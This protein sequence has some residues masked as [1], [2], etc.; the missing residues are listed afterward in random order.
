MVILNRNRTLSQ[1][2]NGLVVSCQPRLNSPLDRAAFV[3]AMAA[4]AE[5]Q[6]AAAVRIRGARDIRAVCRTVRIPVI[7]IEKMKGPESEVY[8][9]PT[10]ESVRHVYRAGARII[11]MDATERPRPY[12]QSLAGIVAATRD[13]CDVLLM[14]DVATLRQGVEAARLGFDL[15]GTTL[16]GYTKETRHCKGP[17]FDLA[18][19]LVRE[20]DIPVILEGRVHKPDDVRRAF[21]LGTHAVVVGTAITDLEWLCRRFI[22][23]CQ[24]RASTRS[25]KGCSSRN[26]L[27]VVAASKTA[28]RKPKS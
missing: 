11:A 27:R 25:A 20:V 22:E 26:K 10:L 15:V 7:G 28:P 1:L 9:T 19:Q 24:R 16:C 4:V 5:E 14:A 21:D 6:E 13:T 23:G 3:A 12:N 17:A 8:I 2:K 18:R